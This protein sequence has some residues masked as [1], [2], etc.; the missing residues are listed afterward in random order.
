MSEPH[1]DG[2]RGAIPE[3]LGGPLRAVLRELSKTSA[4]W[5]QARPACPGHGHPAS[6]DVVGGV[7]VRRCPRDGRVLAPVGEL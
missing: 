2:E 6:P 4:A 5:A 7:A 1:G 3:W